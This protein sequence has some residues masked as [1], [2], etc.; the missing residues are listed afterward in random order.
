MSPLLSLDRCHFAREMSDLRIFGETALEL[1]ITELQEI[2]PA[3]ALNARR[4][5]GSAAVAGK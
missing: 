5:K 2:S 3:A 1:D 4:V